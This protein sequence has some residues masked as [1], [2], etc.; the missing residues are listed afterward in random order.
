[1]TNE[2]A[3]NNELN[4]VNNYPVETENCYMEP[5]NEGGNS[6]GKIA[7]GGAIATII[8]GGVVAWKNKSKIANKRAERLAKKLE[9]KG[10]G[11]IRPEDLVEA[12]AVEVDEAEDGQVVETKEEKK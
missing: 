7:I 6:Y 8:V 4:N 2:T 3:N 11:V 5:E 10:Y 1:M 12:E 9:K